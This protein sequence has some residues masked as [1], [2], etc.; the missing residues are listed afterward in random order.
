MY[1]GVD[2]HKQTHTLVMLTA[3]GGLVEAMTIPNEPAGWQRALMWGRQLAAQRYWGVENSGALGKGF[4]QFLLEQGEIAVHEITP[5][6]TAQYRRRGRTQHKTDTADALAMARL[7][8]AE[9]PL[10]P[11]VQRDDASTELRLLSDQRDHLIVTR[12]RLINQLHAHLLQLD[13]TYRV[14]SGAL[15]SRRG[16]RYCEALT[17]PTPTPLQQTRVLIIHQL[18][19]Q[20]AQTVEAIGMLTVE[21]TRRV[22]SVGARLAALRGLGPVLIARLLGALGS[23]P[24]ITSAAALAALAGIAPIT[25]AS[26]GRGGHRLNRGGNRQLNRVFHL[27]ALCQRR[28]ES[29]AQVYYAKKRAEGKTARAAMRCLKRRLVDVVFHLLQP[30]SAIPASPEAVRAA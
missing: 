27:I 22:R 9:Q 29:R 11:V 5:H 17:L 1:I 3:Q 26:G 24:R 4:A 12:T 20:L 23:L 14:K 2:T 21:L 6:R 7:L 16:L 8:V 15:T 10:L 13:P 18:A 25:V 30:A 28:W 19:A